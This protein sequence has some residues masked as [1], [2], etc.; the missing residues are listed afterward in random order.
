MASTR[1]SKGKCKALLCSACP[2]EKW[3]NITIAVHSSV[4]FGCLCS[5]YIL[6]MFFLTS[7]YLWCLL[8][9]F[10]LF[11]HSSLNVFIFWYIY[12]WDW[13][14]KAQYNILSDGIPLICTVALQLCPYF[15]SL[16]CTP[17][18]LSAFLATSACMN[19]LVIEWWWQWNTELWVFLVFLL[20][21]LFV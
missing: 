10:A 20:V 1:N 3:E 12:F 21:C 4:I 7:Q 9:H 17:H 18:I 16:I 11:L 14:A 19:C 6:I 5:S 8:F 13:M 2:K 15:L